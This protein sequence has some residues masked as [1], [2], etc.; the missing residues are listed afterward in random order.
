MNGNKAAEGQ[1]NNETILEQNATNNALAEDVFADAFNEAEG[2]TPETQSQVT[3]QDEVTPE[4]QNK[5]VEGDEG[6]ITTQNKEVNGEQSTQ[7]VITKT[8]EQ[9]AEESME[10]RWKT[11]QGIHKSEKEK[12]EAERQTLLNQVEEAKKVVPAITPETTNNTKSGIEDFKSILEKLDLTADQKAELAEYEADFDVVSKMEGLKRDKAL[13]KLKAE[14]LQSID[15]IKQELLSKLAPTQEFINET[16]KEREEENRTV[17]FQIVADFHPDYE[18]YVQ[19]GSILKWIESKPAYMRS[20]LMDIYKSGKA[21]DVVEFLNDFKT[22]TNIA[23]NNQSNA[24]SNVVTI[25][26]AKSDRR[27]AITPPNTR[28]GA[29]NT[30]MAP[31]SDFEGAFEE[32]LHKQ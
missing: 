12:W 28:R 8:P 20:G 1:P 15:G 23:T 21:E 4:N 30:S 18:K 14:F 16:Q 5:Q 7:T 22:E 19:D 25:S 29:V 24:E 3:K 10:Q 17:H 2:K 26:K 9:L 27:A 6:N 32:A 11:L 13:M 31:A